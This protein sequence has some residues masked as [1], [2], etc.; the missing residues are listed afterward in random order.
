MSYINDGFDKSVNILNWFLDFTNKGMDVE[1]IDDDA[2][3]G[4]SKSGVVNWFVA[5]VEAI[6]TESLPVNLSGSDGN[7][8]EIDSIMF[9][10]SILLDSDFVE[11]KSDKVDTEELDK[12]FIDELLFFISFSLWELIEVILSS[13]VKFSAIIWFCTVELISVNN[14][15]GSKFK[16]TFGGGLGI[17][18]ANSYGGGGKHLLARESV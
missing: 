18:I 3:I 8:I 17:W 14:G 6:Q 12:V 7:T 16:L 2:G 9:K 15:G 5:D 13:V 11:S 4:I 10:I 1:V